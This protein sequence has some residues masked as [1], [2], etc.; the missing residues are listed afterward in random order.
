ML[1]FSRIDGRELLSFFFS[2]FNASSSP[3]SAPALPSSDGAVNPF[4]FSS[5]MCFISAMAG[6]LEIPSSCKSSDDSIARHMYTRH[7]K[8]RYWQRRSSAGSARTQSTLATE[9]LV[10][11]RMI[12]G[13]PF[14]GFGQVR[15]GQGRSKK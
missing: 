14:L 5:T 2:F 4:D 7:P 8:K 12:R 1:V 3:S 13:M 6:N 11:R 10:L 9:S 15:S